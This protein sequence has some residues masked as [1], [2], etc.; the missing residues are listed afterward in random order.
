[1]IAIGLV[2]FLLS[3]LVLWLNEQHVFLHAGITAFLAVITI[4]SVIAIGS[5]IFL[6]MWRYLP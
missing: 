5:G 6:L 2:V 1:M 3:L 4:G